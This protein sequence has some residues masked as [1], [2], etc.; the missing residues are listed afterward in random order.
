MSEAHELGLARFL[1]QR[2]AARWR[3][4][5][6]RH[7]DLSHFTS[8]LDPARSERLGG[9]AAD[10]GAVVAR[11]V[12]EGAPARCVVFSQDIGWGV[13]RELREAVEE[14]AWT[15]NGGFA[16]CIAGRLALYVEEFHASVVLLRR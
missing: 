7:D 4:V 9:Q 11:L 3:T 8:R 14:L 6:A 15:A 1:T 5:G 12:A 16:S 2:H 10:D 13:E